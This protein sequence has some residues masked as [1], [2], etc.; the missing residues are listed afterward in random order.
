M[1]CSLTITENRNFELLKKHL[2]KSFECLLVLQFETT[3]LEISEIIIEVSKFI[4][5]VVNIDYFDSILL[6]DIQ[7]FS[8][9]C[10]MTR[11]LQQ[12]RQCQHQYRE[13]DLLTLLFEYFRDFALI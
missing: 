12:F 3:R 13:L 10:E 7:K 2:Q 6:C 8:L 4:F 11:F 9:F 1:H 5:V